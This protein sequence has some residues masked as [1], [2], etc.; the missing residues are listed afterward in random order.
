MAQKWVYLFTEGNRDMRNLLGGK[1]AG[2]AEMTNAGLPVPPGFTCT[3]EA[4]LAFYDAGRKF[5]EGMWEQAQAAMKVVEQETGK[6]FGDAVNPLLVSVR[7]GARVSMPGMME[8]VL[9]VG[10]NAE[11]LQG[12]AKLSGNERFAYDSYRRLISMFGRIVK[13]VPGHYFEDILSSYKAKTQG[14][15]DT[16]LTLDMLKLVVADYKAVYKEQVGEDFPE[17]PWQQLAQAIGAVFDSWH[18]RG[19]YP[20]PQHRRQRPV[21]R[22]PRQCPG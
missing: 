6:K 22:V 15:R 19:L 3:T 13:D 16:D 7:S 20:Q 5:P 1:G 2:L 18:G 10:L 9:N 11:T 12:L 4:C 21:R 8:T 17:D 14:G